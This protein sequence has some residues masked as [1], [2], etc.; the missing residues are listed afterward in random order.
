MSDNNCW[1]YILFRR[2]AKEGL[3]AT[4]KTVSSTATL[5]A[6]KKDELWN[7]LSKKTGSV[8]ARLRSLWTDSPYKENIPRHSSD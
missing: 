8:A 3:F 2:G 4:I 5:P 6:E 7:I 1:P